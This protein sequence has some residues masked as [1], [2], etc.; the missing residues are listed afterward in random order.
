MMI[1]VYAF[2]TPNSV[3]VRQGAQKSPEFVARTMA[4]AEG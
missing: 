4:L 1:E 3:N 2:S